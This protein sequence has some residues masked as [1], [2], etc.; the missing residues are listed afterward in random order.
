MITQIE[1]HWTVTTV[2]ARRIVS[3]YVANNSL[4]AA[5]LPALIRSVH[6]VLSSL[7]D[8]RDVVVHVEKPTR[9]QIERSV[10]RD[11]LVSFIDGRAY[12][13]LKRHLTSHGI[14]PHEYRKRYGLPLDYP[15]VAP[16]YAERRSALAKAIGLGR[17][18][19]MAER[20]LSDIGAA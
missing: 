8:A 6:A 1:K 19:A 16:S 15:M 4:P 7:G 17:P 14:D 9:S 18:G 5:E 2:A 12:K 20:A 10:Q 3:A 13:T 11:A